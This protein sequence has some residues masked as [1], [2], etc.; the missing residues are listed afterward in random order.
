MR[1]MLAGTDE[2]CTWRPSSLCLSVTTQFHMGGARRT[3]R[4]K[5]GSPRAQQRDITDFLVSKN[6]SAGQ[7][8]API[9]IDGSPPRPASPPPT[10]RRLT[11]DLNPV[12]GLR[13]L[14]SCSLDLSALVKCHKAH[15]DAT[16]PAAP[17]P[18]PLKDIRPFVRAA[19]E[20][21]VYNPDASSDSESE[22]ESIVTTSPPPSS[23]KR[24]WNATLPCRR[25]VMRRRVET[26]GSSAGTTTPGEDDNSTYSPP[27]V[28][29]CL[30]RGT[31]EPLGLL[32]ISPLLVFRSP[33][34]FNST[35]N[36]SSLEPESTFFPT[37]NAERLCC[38]SYEPK[39]QCSRHV[40]QYLED[41]TRPR[42]TFWLSG[43][44]INS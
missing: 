41:S 39:G 8:D 6:G 11:F 37:F 12:G 5:G 13:A 29:L 23:R 33:E 21:A 42:S 25:R 34:C 27:S 17:A 20:H 28:W 30:V 7:C 18:P 35:S 16:K 22:S 26:V 43:C 32:R 31:Q 10:S 9:V 24:P 44:C 2:L 40:L 4:V 19:K 38:A 14:D 15:V 3:R 36:A 1:P